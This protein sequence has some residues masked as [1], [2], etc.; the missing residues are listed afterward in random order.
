MLLEEKII[1]NLADLLS[2]VS[3]DRVIEAFSD[4]IYGPPHY[5]ELIP[6]VLISATNAWVEES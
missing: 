1:I 5:T 2:L 6:G 4:W 3:T